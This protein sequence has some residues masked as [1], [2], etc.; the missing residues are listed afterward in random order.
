MVALPHLYIRVFCAC[1]VNSAQASLE[2]SLE[3]QIPSNGQ[4]VRS[5]V[6]L[7]AI[8]LIVSKCDRYIRNDAKGI[9]LEDAIYPIQWGIDVHLFRLYL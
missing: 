9:F 5:L 3:D 8:C 2:R 4:T 1:L 6:A 7:A